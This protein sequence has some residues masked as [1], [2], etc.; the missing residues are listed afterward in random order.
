MGWYPRWKRFVSSHVYLQLILLHSCFTSKDR[1][2]DNSIVSSI[3]SPGEI[4]GS[5]PASQPADMDLAPQF[6]I[7]YLLLVLFGFLIRIAHLIHLPW[8][9][10]VWHFNLCSSFK[11][12]PMFSWQNMSTTWRFE[13]GS[14]YFQRTSPWLCVCLCVFPSF[15]R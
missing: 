10:R 1:H 5:Q 6:L 14:F 7:G 3:H 2:K 13:H 9:C 15:S 8:W 4:H 12:Q 11:T